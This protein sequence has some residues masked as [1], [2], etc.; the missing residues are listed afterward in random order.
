MLSRGSRPEKVHLPLKDAVPLEFPPESLN[1][2]LGDLF[3]S[4]RGSRAQH[5]EDAN[6]IFTLTI[7]AAEAAAGVEKELTVYPF[8]C[9]TCNGKGRI[10]TCS[11]CAGSGTVARDE[12]AFRV[13]T[14]CLV[15]NGSGGPLCKT[16]EGRGHD[17]RSQTFS[18]KIPSLARDG[19]RLR[20]GGQGKMTKQGLRGDLY[21]K[22]C[23]QS[24]GKPGEV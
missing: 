12:G 17:L 9:E 19:I 4:C 18:V 8:A 15:C 14:N 11:Q 23:V 3:G 6:I 24:A 5:C 7:T 2:L 10:A 20:L 22:V 21:I 13:Q 16:C 1:G